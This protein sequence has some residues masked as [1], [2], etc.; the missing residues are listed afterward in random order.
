MN[1]TVIFYFLIILLLTALSA[2][3]K[4]RLDIEILVQ[5]RIEA[6]INSPVW[7][8]TEIDWGMNN[9]E[10]ELCS[11]I[12]GKFGF[13]LSVD[14][15]KEK[16]LENAVVWYEPFNFLSLHLGNMKP[17]FGYDFQKSTQDLMLVYRSKASDF[18]KNIGQGSR[19]YGIK[20]CGELPL[21][22]RYGAG[23]YQ[24]QNFEKGTGIFS[25]PQ[26]LTAQLEWGFSDRVVLNA[27]Y[28]TELF[29]YHP[30]LEYRANFY[31]FAI[32]TN[33]IKRK[34]NIDSELFWGD[35]SLI[36]YLF[37]RDT[38]NF[39][40]LSLRIML[41]Y[42]F[43]I[44]KH[45]ISP[46]ISFEYLDNGFTNSEVYTGGIRWDIG[47]SVFLSLDGELSYDN[48]LSGIRD[49]KLIFQVSYLFNKNLI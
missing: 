46:V 5:P 40:T 10:I 41:N 27:G 13:K 7:D 31:D 32:N 38:L 18:I 45:T 21:G 24:S 42:N 3:D 1:K 14:A 34:L 23:I 49:R 11:G 48:E 44:A 6:D 25:V 12:N 17:A 35:P 9:A 2:K 28:R 39:V 4:G 8:S 29:R 22:F 47:P 16:I 43:K 36:D 30:L 26:L 15:A 20:I 19:N 37:Q 33:W